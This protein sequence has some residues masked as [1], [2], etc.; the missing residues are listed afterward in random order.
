MSSKARVAKQVEPSKQKAKMGRPTDYNLDLAIDICE[1]IALGKKLVDVCAP[2]EMPSRTSVYKWLIAYPDFADMYVRARE[3]RGDL[4][5]DEIVNIADTEED[6]NK[7]RVRIDARKW[8]ASKLNQKNYGD[9]LEIGGT[10][11]NKLDESQ[12][13]ARLA[14]LI[15]KAGIA[16]ASG[17][18]GAPE[19]ET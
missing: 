3:E 6:A 9:K 2:D 19:G 10:V 7:A 8:A 4:Y 1:Q 14:I 11:I 15:G 5:A 13:D 12:L 17:G 18:E 16:G